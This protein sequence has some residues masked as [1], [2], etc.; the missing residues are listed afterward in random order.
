MGEQIK[1]EIEKEKLMRAILKKNG[2]KIPVITDEEKTLGTRIIEGVIREL[3]MELPE[4]VPAINLFKLYPVNLPIK[5]STDFKRLY[6][7]PKK[8]ISLHR[9][10][11]DSEI[12][13]QLL[14]VVLHGLLGD[15]SYAKNSRQSKTLWL[16]LD[17]RVN[18]ICEKMGMKSDNSDLHFYMKQMRENNP[19]KAS[20]GNVFLSERNKPLRKKS[21]AAQRLIAVDEHFFWSPEFIKLIIEEIPENSDEETEDNLGAEKKWEKLSKAFMNEVN[22]ISNSDDA[23]EIAKKLNK[24]GKKAGKGAGSDT[25]LAQEAK[26]KPLN[27]KDILSELLRDMEDPREVPD[28]IDPMLYQYGLDMYGDVPLI[29]PKEGD[30]VKK[31]NTICLAIDTSGSCSGQITNLFFRE[32]KALLKDSLDI[33]SGGELLI[34]QCDDAIQNEKIISLNSWA[35][36]VDNH[37]LNKMYGFGGTSF[38]PVFD[39]LNEYEAKDKKIDALIYLTDGYGEYPDKEPDYP[40]IF[41]LTDDGGDIEKSMP[42]WITVGK[43]FA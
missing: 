41:I 34:L 19:Y 25:V 43:L 1:I 22:A 42:D 38:V 9:K 8:I 31:I 30:E 35:S 2:V 27:Y 15:A 26:G 39:R 13:Y 3:K 32:T 16:A 10:G 4:L 7:S 23:N 29:E 5:L 24:G 18:D 17:Q 6:F 36:E 40:V 11:K 28:S 12:K 14:H 21:K 37:D 20:F 33:A